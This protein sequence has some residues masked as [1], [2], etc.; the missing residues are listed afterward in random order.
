MMPIHSNEKIKTIHVKTSQC[1]YPVYIGKGLLT[2]WS[3]LDPYIE[4]HRVLVVTQSSVAH[5]YLSIFRSALTS[6]YKKLQWDEVFLKEGEAHKTLSAWETVLNALITKKHERSTTV[7]ALGGGVV[8]DVAGFAAACYLRGV[9]YIQ[10][11]TTLMAQVDSSVGGKTAVNGLAGKNL[12]GAFHQPQCVLVDVDTLKTLPE[13]EYRAGLAEVIKYA[14]IGDASFFVWIEQH[15]HAILARE[16]DV[17]IEMIYRCIEMKAAIVEQDEK[18]TGIRSLLNFGHTFGHAIEAAYSYEEVL[19]GEAVAMGMWMASRV[20]QKMGWLTAKEVLSIE[21]LLFSLGL[22]PF[23]KKLPS[24]EKLL[25]H[26]KH[27]KKVSLGDLYLI[28]LERVGKAKKVNVNEEWL[29]E[30]VKL[31]I[32]QGEYASP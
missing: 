2:Q 9:H 19:H 14:L 28:L 10:I 15:Q 8:G 16:E 30:S 26:M 4:G 27:D 3:Y 18:E 24:I 22:F 13:R 29:K 5:H 1:T 31:E 23:H 21:Q 7:L 32:N 11:P 25:S 20:S 12:I 6:S 17:L